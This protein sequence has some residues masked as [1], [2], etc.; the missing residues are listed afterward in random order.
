MEETPI[1]FKARC[2]SR[3]L[4]WFLEAVLMTCR[5]RIT[6]QE[7]LL[8]AFKKGPTLIYLWHNRLTLIGTLALKAFPTLRFC[9]FV[10]NSKDGEILAAYSMSFRR[11]STIRVPH[12]SKD[13]ALKM[14][15]NRLKLKRDVPIVT[16]DG[17]KGPKYQVK[18]GIV[19]AARESGAALI[20]FTW[21][22]KSYFE[23][24][25]WDKLRIPKPFSTIEAEFGPAIYLD[26]EKSVEEETPRVKEALES[27][28]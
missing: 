13:R 20:P 26:P 19:L 11:G 12:D 2:I 4:H 7:N 3:L 16:P 23:L 28:S 22:A 18:P 15:I 1:T 5:I 21:R 25:T 8:Q 6:G 9:S 10:S 24:G 14:L 17:P 27:I